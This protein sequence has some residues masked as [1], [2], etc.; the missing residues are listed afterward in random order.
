[1]N[2]IPFR[3]LAR[4]KIANA[5]LACCLQIMFVSLTISPFRLVF[6]FETIGN[7]ILISKLSLLFC[8]YCAA[9]TRAS[10]KIHKFFT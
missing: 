9:F 10:F 3:S 6:G 4:F 1:M 2:A 7:N 8:H 5:L